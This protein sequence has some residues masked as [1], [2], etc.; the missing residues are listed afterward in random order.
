MCFSKFVDLE[1]GVKYINFECQAG[2]I[3]LWKPSFLKCLYDSKSVL[4]SLHIASVLKLSLLLSNSVFL[5]DSLIF[6]FF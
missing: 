6:F 3:E 4:C 5:S 1:K 2:S